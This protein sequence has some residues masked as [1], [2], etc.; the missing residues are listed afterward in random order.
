M[1]LFCFMAEG[2]ELVELLSDGFESAETPDFFG[3]GFQMLEDGKADV[4]L[5]QARGRRTIGAVGPGSRLIAPEASHQRLLARSSFLIRLITRAFAP[6]SKTSLG[7]MESISICS[8]E[9][10][11]PSRITSILMI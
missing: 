11:V 7:L 8:V 9:S 10:D 5:P 4:L 1:S 6:K 3:K 2:F